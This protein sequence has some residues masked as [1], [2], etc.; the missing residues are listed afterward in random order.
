MIDANETSST[1]TVHVGLHGVE[2]EKIYTIKI[3]RHGPLLIKLKLHWTKQYVIVHGFDKDS[4]G[5]SGEIEA[6]GRVSIGDAFLS[7]NGISLS[8][9]L[10]LDEIT[11]IIKSSSDSDSP[12]EL[13]FVK[14]H[15]LNALLLHQ[16]NTVNGND[17]KDG[18][19]SILSL[20]HISEPTRPY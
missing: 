8:N 10:S 11:K 16:L 20:I 5:H 1:S 18:I 19:A 14:K 15:Y 6:D 12:R 7:I 3:N 2:S 13:N 9:G 4:S 17:T